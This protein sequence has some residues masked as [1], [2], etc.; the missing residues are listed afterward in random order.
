MQSILMYY[1]FLTTKLV[2]LGKYFIIVR[3]PLNFDN[4]ESFHFVFLESN[5]N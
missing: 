3:I 1:Y 4:L 5:V 2:R